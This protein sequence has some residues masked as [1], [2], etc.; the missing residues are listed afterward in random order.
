VGSLGNRR[1]LAGLACATAIAVP[2]G[3]G[4]DD[5][6]GGEAPSAEMTAREYV[7]AQNDGDAATI[8]ALYSDGLKEE[9]GAAR[10]CPAFVE[11]Q[12]SG[13]D[14]DFRL[15]RVDENGDRATATL[16]ATTAEEGG[17]EPVPLTI[18]LERQDETW[19]ITDL[20]S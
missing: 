11:E 9:I 16:E 4:G 10:N 19:L 12:S 7:D 8:C 17:Q 13:A 14:T 3:C 15:I 20:G 2:I 18:T 5:D 1:A 6:G